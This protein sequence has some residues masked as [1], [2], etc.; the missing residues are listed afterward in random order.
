M[1]PDFR[2]NGKSYTTATLQIFANKLANSSKTYCKEVGEFLN[3]WL[4]TNAYVIVQTSGSTGAPKPIKLLKKHMT[5]SAL[6][7]GKYFNTLAGTKAL[8][9]LSANYIAGKMMLVRAMVLGWDI[10]IKPPSAQPI[11]EN[12]KYDFVAMVPIQVQQSL[13]YLNQIKTLIIGGAPLATTIYNQLLQKTTACYVT[14]GMTETC[15]HIAIKKINHENNTPYKT[16]SNITISQDERDC[17]VI[18]APKITSVAI[19]TNDIVK[20][21]APNKFLWLGRHDS[22]INS[23]GIKLFPEQIEQKL[24]SQITTRFFVAGIPDK[25]LGEK[26][27]L[28]IESNTQYTLN[29]TSLKTPLLKYEQPKEVFFLPK[30]IETSTGKIQRKKTLQLLPLDS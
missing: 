12:E 14:Y 25:V 30:F 16:L 21:I 23:G 22:V 15:T 18:N 28:L 5:N 4:N 20:I 6:A 13:S 26:L 19:T 2:I 8:L 7:T 17:L 9:C 27:I 11:E 29:Y 10:H 3:I 1:H 24:S